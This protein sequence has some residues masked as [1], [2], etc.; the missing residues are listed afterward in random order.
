[1]SNGI[2]GSPSRVGGFERV[3]G[4][5][6]YVADI[7]LDG[8]LYVKL[9]TVDHAR[10]RI[11]AI[12]ASAAMAVPGVRAVLTAADLPRAHAALRT[13]V[14]GPAGARGRRDALPR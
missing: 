4:A 3:T 2:G 8:E 13:A 7:H 6:A 12:D 10:F 14:P 11:D 9:V 1:M 5:Q